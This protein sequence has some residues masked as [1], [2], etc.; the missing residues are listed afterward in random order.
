[1]PGSSSIATST[2]TPNVAG[3]LAYLLGLITGVLF[4]VMEPYKRDRFVRFHAMQSILFCFAW[5]V[6]QMAW[7]I[8]WGILINVS[9]SLYIFGAPLRLL[10]S[11]GLFLYW[12]YV[13]YQAYQ[14]K[15]YRI[16]IIGAIAAQQAG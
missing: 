13:M 1:M 16:P 4:L 5:I 10:I 9:A 11:L 14:Q 6:I 12:L 2:L 15:E 3:A 8:F 7:R